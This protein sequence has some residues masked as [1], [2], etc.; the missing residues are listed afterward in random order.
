ML[1][2]QLH[3]WAC[4]LSATPLMCSIMSEILS[5]LL[6]SLGEVIRA[7]ATCHIIIRL[8]VLLLRYI[9]CQ[10]ARGNTCSAA[11]LVI[12]CAKKKIYTY[13]QK[14]AHKPEW[15]E[16]DGV[17]VCLVWRDALYWCSP[18][19][20]CWHCFVFCKYFQNANVIF[21]LMPFVFVFG[22]DRNLQSRLNL[23]PN[24]MW[25][26]HAF[27]L[28]SKRN[29]DASFKISIRIKGTKDI[30]SVLGI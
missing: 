19:L 30:S 21:L 18:W 9:C 13:P 24:M 1:F 27:T 28:P 23:N 20:Y 26:A 25:G 16:A 17:G 14:S 7:F 29:S 8:T 2:T 6:G 22:S 3:S 12:M 5:G 15:L 10:G 11:A 4:F